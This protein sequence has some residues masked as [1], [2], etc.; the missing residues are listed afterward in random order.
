MLVISGRKGIGNLKI[1]NGKVRI[2]RSYL[3]HAVHV[4]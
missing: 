2:Y 4:L 3:M 1:E